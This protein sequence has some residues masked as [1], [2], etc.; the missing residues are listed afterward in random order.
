MASG[1]HALFAIFVLLGIPLVWLHFLRRVRRTER[2]RRL[3]KVLGP[4][5]ERLRRLALRFRSPDVD[6]DRSVLDAGD[7]I[8]ERYCPIRA[9]RIAVVSLASSETDG[10]FPSRE[11]RPGIC[12]EH[13][14]D[15]CPP[16]RCPVFEARGNRMKERLRWLLEE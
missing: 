13:D 9:R 15:A 4:S 10:W 1:L 12:F 3:Q 16:N 8:E 7:R 2:Q 14:D 5:K 6:V 11:C